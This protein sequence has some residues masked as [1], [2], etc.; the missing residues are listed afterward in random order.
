MSCS[1]WRLHHEMTQG[2]IDDFLDPE[3]LDLELE[4]EELINDGE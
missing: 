2:E 1:Y 3:N 4:L